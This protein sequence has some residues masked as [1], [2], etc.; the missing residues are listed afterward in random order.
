[1]SDPAGGTSREETRRA[2]LKRLGLAVTVAYVAPAITRLEP[3]RA[4][5]PSPGG[6]PPGSPLCH[7]PPPRR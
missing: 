3:A 1:M 4:A 7:R 5:Q 6:C 2:A